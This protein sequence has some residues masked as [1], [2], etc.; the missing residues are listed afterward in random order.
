[1]ADTPAKNKVKG[2]RWELD[3]L[4]YFRNRNLITE[5]LRLAGKHDEG[6]LMVYLNA[7]TV[8]V[9][10]A[11]NEKSFKLG[12]WIAEAVTEAVNWGKARKATV[13]A[14]PIVVAKRRNHSTSKAYV[15]MELDTFMETVNK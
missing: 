4:D 12:P 1:M 3:L 10:E 15:I 9:V 2:A 14:I 8:L 5:R 13:Q 6:D 11:K 7:Q